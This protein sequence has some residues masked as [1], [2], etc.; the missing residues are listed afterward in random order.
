MHQLDWARESLSL[1]EHLDVLESATELAGCGI[2][3]YA[4]DAT[5]G[6]L[7]VE[8]AN[9]VMLQ[10]LQL[11]RL[12]LQRDPEA[13][14]AKNHTLKR[15]LLQ[16]VHLGE[17]A[18]IQVT[19][20]REDDST[21]V[22]EANCR[23][24]PS[25]RDGRA[26]FITISRDITQQRKA[27]AHFRLLA[28]SVEEERDAVF[29]VRMGGTDPLRPKLIYANR[30]F[31]ELT[32]YSFDEINGGAYPKI[33]GKETDL[34]KVMESVEL[35]NAGASVSN[36]ILLYRKDGSTFWA[37]YRGNPIDVP[38]RH[39]VI[40]VRD[41]TERRAQEMQIN[42][43]SSA[44]D[45]ASDFV[46]IIEGKPEDEGGARVV[47]VNDAVVR[48]MGYAREELV[49][50]SYTTLY[51]PDNAPQIV[52][53][54]RNNISTGRPN[55]CEILFKRKDAAP[56]W[57]EFVARPFAHASGS[58][59]YRILVGRDITLRRRAANQVALLLA[60][61]EKSSARTVLYERG[62]KGDLTVS[63]ENPAA[64][65]R[66][67]Y[68]LLDLLDGKS[69]DAHAARTALDRGEEFRA[70]YVERDKT[71][72]E[73]VEFTARPIRNIAGLEAV[74]TQEHVVIP[75]VREDA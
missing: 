43:L 25:G 14:F 20:T 5:A 36:E 38:E 35:V 24:L 21:Y 10:R 37:E 1:Q 52:E 26:R 51:S 65:E 74:L 44:V 15:E 57:L 70:F 16:R 50:K 33:L 9:D 53:S 34:A 66:A 27:D 64:A 49:G 67:R 48:G 8:Y 23:R 63:Y 54:I 68:R 28:H 17:S 59:N 39:C 13:L 2:A 30:S 29:I 75:D 6:K 69:T 41:V 3:V 45:E 47:Y 46:I 12:Q 56:F 22:I 11:T 32:G 60:G 62:D 7:N 73:I 72:S 18:P 71:S 19:V 31:C 4:Y 55:F 42:L 40:L 61:I 58:G